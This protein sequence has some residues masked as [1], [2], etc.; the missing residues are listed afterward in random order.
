MLAHRYP[1]DVVMVIVFTI[2][3]VLSTALGGVVALRN[4]DRLHLIL[5]LTAGVLLGLVLFD[6]LPEVFSG[7]LAQFGGVPV[8]MLTAA[9][10]FL[11]LHVTERSLAIHSGH[12][13]EY[14]LH[15]HHD[16]TIG[17]VSAGALVT[18]SF[19]DGI[20]IG[21]GFQAGE[22]VGITVAVAVVAHDFADGLN[23]V[24]IVRAH[25]NT[26]GR[27]RALLVADATAPLLGAA[28]TLLFT[29]P[30]GWLKA[31]LGFF[32]GFLVYLATSDILPEAHAGHPSRLTLMSTVAGLGLMW[33]VVGLS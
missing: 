6:L 16:H 33:L 8:P 22:A 18:H 14:D 27:A 25:G 1:Y 21:L 4:P 26:P 13:H 28:S 3:S 17:L 24:A 9:G 29:L 12:E 20:G 7:D 23:T 5:G 31:Y 10:G 32:I 30:E 15:A 11:A 2:A 19:L